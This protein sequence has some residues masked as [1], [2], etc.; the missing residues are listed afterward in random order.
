M[1][2]KYFGNN[3]SQLLQEKYSSRLALSSKLRKQSFAELNSKT[4]QL[5]NYFLSGGIKKNDYVIIFCENSFEYVLAI[6]SLWKIAAVPV[7]VN[8][9]LETEE[10][11]KIFELVRPKAVISDKNNFKFSD[12]VKI[13]KLTENIFNSDFNSYKDETNLNS[14]IILFTSGSLGVPKGVIHTLGNIYNS[15]C[16]IDKVE[17]FSPNDVFLLSLPLYHIGGLMI[18]FRSLFSGAELFFPESLK[19]ELLADEILNRNINI[20]SLVPTQLQRI[21]ESKIKAPS[22]LRSVYIGGAASDSVLLIKAKELGWKIKKVY[23]STETCS[24]ATLFD[25]EKHQ[26]KTDSSGIPLSNNYIFIFNKTMQHCGKNEI[27]EIAIQS[28]CLFDSYFPEGIYSKNTIEDN[29][30]LTGDSG[31]IDEDGFLFVK[32]RIKKMIISGGENIDPDEV[33]AA[34]KMINEIREAYVFGKKNKEWGEIVC[35]AIEADKH[36]TVDSLKKEL[37]GKI[38]R[39]KMP[40]EIRVIKSFPRNS[41]GKIKYSYLQN[42][43]NQN[44]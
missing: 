12:S 22:Y 23:G 11:K 39:Y 4:S 5:Q 30:F 15:V 2:L 20:V 19:S 41:M 6:L 44:N 3:L 10:F 32:R 13:V 31:F 36:F 33:E 18:F 40:K 27:G 38:A 28:N 16:N 29:I 37:N 42:L 1:V 9:H 21:I 43:F 34:I 17:N 14:R 7:L 26:G 8:S 24:M 25:M 35:A